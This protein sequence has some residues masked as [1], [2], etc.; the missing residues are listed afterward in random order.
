[1][2]FFTK[3]QASSGGAVALRTEAISRLHAL[4]QSAAEGRKLPNDADR[5]KAAW[6]LRRAWHQ[7]KQAGLKKQDFQDRVFEALSHH[8]ARREG[9]KLANYVLPLRYESVNDALTDYEAACMASKKRTEPLR[10]L[11]PYLKGIGIA[12][13]WCGADPDDWKLAFLQETSLWKRRL[14]SS[15]VLDQDERPAETIALLFSAL[16]AEIARRH[17]LAKLYTALRSLACRWEM[18]EDR[19]VPSGGNCMQWIESPVS[20]VFES[21]V[22]F[23]EGMPYPSVPLLRVP[24]LAASTRL[25]VALEAALL[26]IDQ[27]HANSPNY[28]T[29]GG[30]INFIHGRPDVVHY[31]FP[32]DAPDQRQLTADLFF[33]R[34]IRLCVVPDGRG[35]FTA[36]LESRPRVELS[37]PDDD[38]LAGHHA[39][40]AAWKPDFGESLFYARRADDG[41]VFPTIRD[42]EDRSWRVR[43]VKPETEAWQVVMRDPE[44]TGW[45][46]DQDPVGAP[47]QVEA[48]PWYLSYTPATPAYL[49]HWLTQ[50]W[51][52]A[53]ISASCPWDRIGGSHGADSGRYNRNLPPLY[54]LKFSAASAANSIECCLHNGLIEDALD[55]AAGRLASEVSTLQRNWVSASD[56]HV[57]TL[58]NR[59]S[60]TRKKET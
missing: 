6:H 35:G 28:L 40:N 17:E 41:P 13:G 3:P 5:L 25:H 11:E 22:Y 54:E 60:G 30:A 16:C 23:E 48:E 42:S 55:A 9:F 2:D 8:H 18:F 33:L 44:T 46:F 14:P 20:P 53:D 59:W 43:V 58:L 52:L 36:G 24:Y 21:A 57:H 10:G 27:A 45:E 7:A 26:E 4:E 49:A 50:N 19:L 56:A 47:G 38:P 32:A 29:G 1:M 12:A 15:G 31:T 39:V 51:S 34:E 37:I